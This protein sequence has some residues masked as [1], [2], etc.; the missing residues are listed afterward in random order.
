MVGVILVNFVR[1]KDVSWHSI[2]AEFA[3]M[4]YLVA[5]WLERKE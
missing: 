1:R 5:Y 4:Y 3:V 2:L